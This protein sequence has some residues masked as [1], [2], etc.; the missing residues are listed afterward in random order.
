[1]S[2]TSCETE[3]FTKN[4]LF[5]VSQILLKITVIGQGAH[6][7]KISRLV[8]SNTRAKVYLTF[9]FESAYGCGKSL[10]AAQLPFIP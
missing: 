2:Q 7:I 4:Y 3:N 8:L 5:K 6:V 9:E 10:G 1:M